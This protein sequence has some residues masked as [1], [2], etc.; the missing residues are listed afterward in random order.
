MDS[1]KALDAPHTPLDWLLRGMVPG[2]LLHFGLK[3]NLEP[4]RGDVTW[5]HCSE[6]GLGRVR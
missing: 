6:S 3:L 5:A 4:L 1:M 2:F